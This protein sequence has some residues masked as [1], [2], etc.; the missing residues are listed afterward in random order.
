MRSQFQNGS[1]DAAIGK[2]IEA[3][4]RYLALDEARTE[5]THPAQRER[6]HIAILRAYLELLVR[7][8]VIAGLQYADGMEFAD[9][10]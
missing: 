10:Q 9:A 7:A 4:Q 8:R 5:C 1:M 6:M 2:F 3:H